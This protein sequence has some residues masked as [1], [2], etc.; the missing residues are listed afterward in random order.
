M[1]HLISSSGWALTLLLLFLP[2]RDAF[3][4]GAGQMTDG[5]MGGGGMMMSGWMMLVC[6]VFGL[7]LLAVLVLVILALLKYLRGERDS[8]DRPGAP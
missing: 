3:A 7:M 4:R 5:M 8:H 6:A 1:N 2:N